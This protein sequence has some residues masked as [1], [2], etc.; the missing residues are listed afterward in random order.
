MLAAPLMAGNDLRNMPAAIREILT[1]KEAI[2]VNQDALGHQAIKYR[3]YGDVQ[4]WAK[5][6]SGHAMAYAALNRS[7]KPKEVSEW[8]GTG[9]K[10]RDLWKHAEVT[11]DDGYF[12]GT[13]APHSVVLL[14]ATG[15]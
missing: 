13:L 9:K 7:D 5:E 2:A 4:I 15:E 12:R 11:L 3:D 1:N 8:I 6:L 14:K 10:V